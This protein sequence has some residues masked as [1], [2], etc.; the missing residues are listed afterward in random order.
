[1]AMRIRCAADTMPGDIKFGYGLATGMAIAVAIQILFM[2]PLV[3]RNP[4]S[5]GT[6]VSSKL[7]Q[8]EPN[9]SVPTNSLPESVKADPTTIAQIRIVMKGNQQLY[10]SNEMPELPKGTG[11]VVAS[12]K[13]TLH[14]PV[15]S[16]T[17]SHLQDIGTTQGHLM[18]EMLWAIRQYK[19][20]A[21]AEPKGPL[22]LDIGANVGSVA[23]NA[24]KAG[25]RVAAFETRPSMVHSLRRTL[26]SAPWLIESLVLYPMHLG[27]DTGDCIAIS[28]DG[29]DSGSRKVCLNGMPEAY[30]GLPI[31]AVRQRTVW[32]QQ[33]STQLVVSS[34]DKLFDEHIQV[35]KVD[36][37]SKEG[38]RPLV[39]QGAEALLR[40][41]LVSYIILRVDE[42]MWL[43]AGI[44]QLLSFMHAHNYAC[45][46]FGFQ[47]SLIHDMDESYDMDVYCS[48]RRGAESVKEAAPASRRSR[49]VM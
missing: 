47:G 32:S 1:M 23:V 14:G 12:D 10:C 7:L 36:V 6:F 18:R 44:D 17:L 2:L 16:Y 9:T 49:K 41:G 19:V 15:D 48:L 40:K 35:M 8:W 31:N 26:C 20:P 24:V 39:L 46:Y 38:G 21:N 43:L 30:S 28:S 5:F 11:R 27:F 3:L 45:S 13:V 33:T 37:H 34:L 42:P 22:V 25:A 4:N 29:Y